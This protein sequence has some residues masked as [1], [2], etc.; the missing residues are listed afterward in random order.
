MLARN[1]AIQLYLCQEGSGFISSGA[2]GVNIHLMPFS[3]VDQ[4]FH[5]SALEAESWPP[6]AKEVSIAA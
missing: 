4:E 5:T 6:L 3:T 2:S 1:S